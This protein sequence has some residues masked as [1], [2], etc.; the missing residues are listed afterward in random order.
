VKVLNARGRNVAGGRRIGSMLPLVVTAPTLKGF[1][2]CNGVA[3]A[4]E[5]EGIGLRGVGVG[6][7]LNIGTARGCSG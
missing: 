3:N 1:I 6:G 2:G 5:E 4:G 7:G